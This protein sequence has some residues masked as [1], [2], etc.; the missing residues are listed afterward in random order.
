MNTIQE[1]RMRAALAQRGLSA[2]PDDSAL[3]SL[4][5]VRRDTKAADPET[6]DFVK[7]VDCWRAENVTSLTQPHQGNEGSRN[8]IL[9]CVRKRPVLSN[10][11]EVVSNSNFDCITCSTYLHGKEE[12]LGLFTGKLSAKRQIFDHTFGASANNANIYKVLVSPLI[13][14][15][16]DCGICTILS[17]GQTGSGKTYTCTYIQEQAIRDIYTAMPSDLLSSRNQLTLRTDQDGHINVIGLTEV[18]ANSVDEAISIVRKG[19]AERA[20]A[21]TGNNPESSR[22]HAILRITLR[23]ITDGSLQGMLRVVDLAGSERKKHVRLHV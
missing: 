15:C 10:L 9:V 1:K 16:L 11:G 13:S 7:K 3:S 18:A 22:S 8:N 6:F 23:N 14:R 21:A 5:E 4:M 17:F 12:K 19:S 2:V 20:T